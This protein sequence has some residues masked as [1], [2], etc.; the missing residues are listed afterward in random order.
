MTNFNY[1][2]YIERAVKSALNQNFDETQM[3]VIVI[4]D[5]SEDNSMETL[6]AY[7]DK[8]ILISQNN[9][10]LTCSLNRGIKKA[11]GQYIMRL[12][13]DD[14]LEP[15]TLSDTVPILDRNNDLSFVYFDYLV[16]DEKTQKETLVSLE[17]FNLFKM[18]GTNLLIR[19]SCFEQI[20]MN[21]DMYFEEYDFLI[22]LLERFEGCHI[23]Q[24]FLKY[25]KHGKGMT[26]NEEEW[27]KGVRQLV[28]K[29][30]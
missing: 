27:K 19:T 24:I 7:D 2:Q 28:E 21:E 15:D 10:G 22:R 13:A 9:Q 25:F 16:I 18:V 4:D 26:E 1:G 23:P 5:G 3:E 20:G 17:K 29:Y 12:D 14:I 30:G 8:I 11:Q 6:K